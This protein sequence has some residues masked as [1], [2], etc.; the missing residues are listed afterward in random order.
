MN[1]ASECAHHGAAAACRAA[2]RP[3]GVR[4]ALHLRKPDLRQAICVGR[5]VCAR[6]LGH[7]A[8]GH[9][10]HLLL[11]RRRHGGAA[12]HG[13]SASKGRVALH[14]FLPAE[15]HRHRNRGSGTRSWLL[16][17]QGGVPGGGRLRAGGGGCLLL[18]CTTPLSALQGRCGRS[19]CSQAR[20][21]MPSP[22]RAPLGACWPAHL[23]AW[24]QLVSA[25]SRLGS[26]QPGQQMSTQQH[27]RIARSSFWL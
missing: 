11:R 12:A 14:G 24:R 8:G 7:S 2:P 3:T 20:G 19:P 5:C 10:R 1:P 18:A 23:S 16:P 26:A 17:S 21:D 4:C 25:A 6:R 9:G 22:W 27:T 13:G 15:R